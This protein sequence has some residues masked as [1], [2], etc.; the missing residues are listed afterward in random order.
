MNDTTQTDAKEIKA[1][2]MSRSR[3]QLLSSY[4]PGKLF[5][6]E[7]G[8]GSC[9]I[10]PVNSTPFPGNDILYIQMAYLIE[11]TASG[12]YSVGMRSSDNVAP[13]QVLDSSLLTEHGTVKRLKKLDTLFYVMKPDQMG[14][15][16][17]PLTY[18]CDHCDLFLHF[19]N[20]VRAASFFNSNDTCPHCG[21]K[22]QWR[23]VDVVNVHPSGRVEPLSPARWNVDE[24][25]K[26]SQW[27][28]GCT[29]CG[30]TKYTLDH[31]SSKLSEWQFICANPNCTQPR[32]I[33]NND[34]ETLE[35]LD[36]P[37]EHIRLARFRASPAN[38]SST[39]YTVMDQFVILGGLELTDSARLEKL[40][41][42]ISRDDHSA[43]E[44]FIAQQYGYAGDEMSSEDIIAHLEKKN[45]KSASDELKQA[46]KLLKEAKEMN[47]GIG[48]RLSEE[49]LSFMKKNFEQAKN[50]ALSACDELQNKAFQAPPE[51]RNKLIP[52]VRQEFSSRYDP[53]L[54]AVEH[55]SLLKDIIQSGTHDGSRVFVP[56][57]SLD[58]LLA[59]NDPEERA[60]IEGRVN[61]AMRDLGL[62]EVGLLRK[63]PLC[64]F[65]YGFTRRESKPCVEEQNVIMP[66]RLN[67]FPVLRGGDSTG[68]KKSHNKHPIYAINQDNEALYFR[69]RV[70]AVCRWLQAFDVPLADH[71]HWSPKDE[72]AFGGR[73]LER[74]LPWGR[75]VDKLQPEDTYKV[76]PM[77]YTLLHSFAHLVINTIAQESG[78]DQASLG[79]YL[80]PAD[81][82]FVVYRN[83]ATMDLGNISSLWR[84][85]RDALLS[86]MLSPRATQCGSG[87]LCDS[88]GGACPDCI[89]IPEVS[90]LAGNNLLTRAV[91]R[92]GPNPYEASRKCCPILPG[93]FDVNESA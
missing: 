8:Q 60:A 68:H 23:Q 89:M 5:S 36:K 83:G 80:F 54:L 4:A 69:L 48:S 46:D 31:R 3:S 93:F 40:K 74:A 61:Q 30:N 25:G 33:I 64:R 19:N 11:D 27:S 39:H 58:D 67:L 84:S 44:K 29:S 71:F 42:I 38:A 92:S 20:E 12:W 75:Y 87:S 49:M 86:D 70:D 59:P 34:R 32:D 47:Q 52:E 65:S 45:L 2:L 81:L 43:L 24:D 9:R 22:P 37:M 62:E 6:F 17:F 55:D 79:E 85:R 77:V 1:K 56:F 26:V 10:L 90:C 53:F 72:I 35:I 13:R 66:V 88:R 50:K 41:E 57:N 28:S 21:G 16:V 76:Y 82:A 73:L 63:F 15:E 78:L 14:Y 7:D 18:T 51:I 91:L